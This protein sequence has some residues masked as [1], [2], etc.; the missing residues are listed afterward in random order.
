VGRS[1]IFHL[2][3]P[4]L[5]ALAQAR[6]GAMAPASAHVAPKLKDLVALAGDVLGRWGGTLE[7]SREL[8]AVKLGSRSTG[9]GQSESGALLDRAVYVE[10]GAGAGAQGYWT[11]TSGAVVTDSS[12]AVITRPTL[13]QILALGADW[14]LEQ[15]WSPASRATPLTLRDEAP[16]L[17][18][19]IAGRAV[20]LDYG[21]KQ[22]DGTWH[23]A[24]APGLS[25]ATRAEITA[26][27]HASGTQWR[28]EDIQH[29]P[30]ANL[31][32]AQIGVRFT[33]G[34]VVDY[35]VQVTD[36]NGAFYVW[37]R[38]LDRALQLQDKTGSATEFNL[39]NYEVDFAH[40]DEVGSADNSTYRVERSW[41]SRAVCSVPKARSAANDD[42]AWPM[43]PFHF[44]MGRAA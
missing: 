44:A 40:L 13:E 42:D 2:N 4:E 34:A 20:I 8:I 26:L 6:S 24:S 41:M 28:V 19:V 17:M 7:T 9:S 1:V 23:L 10:D 21:I 18:R 27:P 22:A 29:N 43:R 12:G 35:T 36:G 30:L 25:Y 33:G 16:Y 5:A 14:R 31:P 15:A 37:A 3:D 11:L 32:V 39:R 38:N